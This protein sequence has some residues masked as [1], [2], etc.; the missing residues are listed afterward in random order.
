MKKPS[1]KN[2]LAEGTLTNAL[3]QTAGDTVAQTPDVVDEP[4]FIKKPA[5]EWIKAVT[6]QSE[7]SPAIAL[8]R[9]VYLSGMLSNNLI[10][11]IKSKQSSI[12]DVED[13]IISPML[14]AFEELKTL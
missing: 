4:Q 2:A 10:T 12:K 9:A 3:P 5:L 8:S 7:I 13:V 6:I 11:V 14:K 1:I